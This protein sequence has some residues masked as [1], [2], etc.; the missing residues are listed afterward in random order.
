ME[1]HP[2]VLVGKAEIKEEAF[3]EDMDIAVLSVLVHIGRPFSSA[4]LMI[5]ILALAVAASCLAGQA[6]WGAVANVLAFTLACTFVLLQPVHAFQPFPKAEWFMP[7]VGMLIFAGP[8]L[9]C[10]IAERVA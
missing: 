1:K 9:G 7:Y 2:H 6:Q 3:S 8:A 10:A 5:G 4:V